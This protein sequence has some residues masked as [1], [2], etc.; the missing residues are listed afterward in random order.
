MMIL[1]AHRGNISG[2]N[3]TRENSPEYIVEALLQGYQ[4]EVDMWFSAE[5]GI[6]LGHDYPQYQVSVD[7]ISQQGLWLHCKNAAALDYLY[8][9]D[10]NYFWHERD[11]YTIT[12]H[13]YIWA[14]P[15]KEAVGPY[16]KTICCMPEYS[17]QNINQFTGVCTDFV[18]DYK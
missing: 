16:S 2:P 9:T 8:N 6:R 5:Y 17:S 1:I 13:K 15:G 3:P 14:Y 18:N 4:C 12:S 7:F 10:L 11:S